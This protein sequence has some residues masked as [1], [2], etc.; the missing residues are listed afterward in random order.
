MTGAFRMTMTMKAALAVAGMVVGVGD[1]SAQEYC[2]S[3]ADPVATY[4]CII[5]DARA[6][7]GT[8]LQM[9]CVSQ[10]AEMA[11]HAT[12]AIK[13]VTVLECDGQIVRIAMPRTGDPV[14]AAIATPAPPPPRPESKP[15]DTLVGVVEEAGKASKEGLKS[16]GK[17]IGDSAKKTWKCMTSLFSRC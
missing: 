1:V 16:A 15:P 7:S 13:R 8:P 17:A 4:R 14:P 3:C 12:C 10:M 2:V 5:D 6:T 11:K 9:L